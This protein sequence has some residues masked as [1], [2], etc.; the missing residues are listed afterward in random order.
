M[1]AA[2]QAPV[3]EYANASRHESQTRGR[4]AAAEYAVGVV[5]EHYAGDAAVVVEIETYM[6]QRCY[7]SEGSGR[8]EESS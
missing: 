6:M 3:G 8:K 4:P 5:G 2:V 7:G 1:V